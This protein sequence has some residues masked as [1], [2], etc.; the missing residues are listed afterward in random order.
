[1][2]NTTNIPRDKLRDFNTLIENQELVPHIPKTRL[3]TTEW[4]IEMLH[5]H[6]IL[7]IKPT[8]AS[9]GMGIM[10]VDRMGE[11]SYMLR[12]TQRFSFYQDISDLTEAVF[13]LKR[14]QSYLIQQGIISV[15]Q[16]NYPFDIRAHVIKV[17]GVWTFGGMIGKVAKKKSIITNASQGAVPTHIDT[18]LTNFRGL[19]EEQSEEVKTKIRRI[20]LDAAQE[21][22][23]KHP[24]W[25]EFGL[26]IGIDEGNHIWIYEI[27]F[28]PGFI[29][30][31]YID[32]PAYLFIHSL[33]KQKKNP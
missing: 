2:M 20:A 30:F 7:Y 26:D 19:N 10:R 1:M 31:R 8:S 22:D 11:S 13:Q 23:K 4:M 3:L 29:L 17:N 9:Q 28:R 24:K 32:Q 27:N 18:I 5:D 16:L 15:T 12:D 6:P 21:M 25:S 33:R 14:K